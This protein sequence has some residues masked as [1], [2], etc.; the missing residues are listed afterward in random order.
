MRKF[1][2][3][4]LFGI[5]FSAANP[6][7]AAG[8]NSERT[9][10]TTLSV[11][12][13]ADEVDAVPTGRVV[14]VL[15]SLEE[16]Y[17]SV[18]TIKGTFSQTTLDPTFGETIESKG[19]FYLKKPNRLR[20]DYAPPHQTTLL[21]TERMMYRYIPQ[22]KQVER[23]RI[24]PSNAIVATNYMLLGFGANTQDVLHAYRVT[25]ATDKAEIKATKVLR[26][27]PLRPEE[28]SFKAIE[29][30]VDTE[31]RIPLEFRVTQLD[32]TV[33][34]VKLDALAMTLDAPLDDK[35]FRPSFPPDAQTVDVK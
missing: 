15:K 11:S 9:T 35:L 31:Q 13:G 29:M 3:L 21:V 19:T 17:E 20:I 14:E 4:L 10:P 24:D 2:Q 26:L 23:Y 6:M 34:T 27:I 32:G 12:K 1:G 22:L 25:L 18:K 16:R 7:F 5:V 8:V 30:V 33:A 28:A